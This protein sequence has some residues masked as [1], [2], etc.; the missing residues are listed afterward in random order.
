ML[1]LRA[2]TVDSAINLL[3][4]PL[5]AVENRAEHGLV[6]EEKDLLG[7]DILYLKTLIKRQDEQINRLS[8]YV[9]DL[10]R[11]LQSS[12][13][14]VLRLQKKIDII[15]SENARNVKLHKEILFREKEI[16]R[17]SIELA[18]SKKVNR[19]LQKRAQKLKDIRI[20]EHT[21]AVQ[22]VKSVKSFNRD[23]IEAADEKF[24][25]AESIILLEDA[26]GG[27]L[28]TAELL[29]N[30]G[31]RAVVV[32]NEMSEVARKTLFGADVPVFSVGDLPMQLSGDI[33]TI[34]KNAL[35]IL[36]EN[37]KAEIANAKQQERLDRLESLVQAYK[38]D[39]TKS[40][41]KSD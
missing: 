23:A 9:A 10:K 17:L 40:S 33:L 22:A 31:I 21:M 2:H 12:Q 5:A 35:E 14:N 19:T 11:S 29:V 30:K 18:Q 41:E 3:R 27:G 38:H 13:K 20:A 24:G 25:L 37:G 8:S 4:K 34:D 36:I 15:Q 1:V 39:R 28:G 26:S 6:A 32:K 7:P 16:D